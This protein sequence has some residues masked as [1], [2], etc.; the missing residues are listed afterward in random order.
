M[1]SVRR[2]S[3]FVQVV[4]E[5]MT[6]GKPAEWA[7]DMHARIWTAR[8]FASARYADKCCRYSY[9]KLS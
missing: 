5:D 4:F 1:R 8:H 3:G 7:T 2:A 6:S 9:P